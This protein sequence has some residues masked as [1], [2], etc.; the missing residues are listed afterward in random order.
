VAGEGS[1]EQ[2]G[3]EECLELMATQRVGRLGVVVDGFPLVLPMHF[4]LDGDTV[5]MQTN[6]GAKYLSA[7]LTAVSFEVDQ[8]DLEEGVGWSVLVSG[9]AEDISSTIDARSEHLRR[10]ATHSW[11]PPPA[12]RWLKIVPRQ[13]SGRRLRARKAADPS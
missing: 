9:Y 5:V 7:P 1:V 6:E 11:A 2:M 8:V 3:P 13:I 4:A 10:L 12:D